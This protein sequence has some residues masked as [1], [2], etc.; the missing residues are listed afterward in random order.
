MPAVEGR[1]PPVTMGDSG[2]GNRALKEA[3]RCDHC[4]GVIFDAPVITRE[5]ELTGAVRG[6]ELITVHKCRKK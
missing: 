1:D 4:A 3:L 2:V 5:R 6:R